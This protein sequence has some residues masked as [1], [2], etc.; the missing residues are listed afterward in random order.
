MLKGISDHVAMPAQTQVA[1]AYATAVAEPVRLRIIAALA[2]APRS[3]AALAAAVRVDEAS[4]F[5]HMRPLELLGLV[6][7]V[8]GAGADRTYMLVREP[9]IDD[10]A[11]ERLPL[12]AR[13]AAAASTVTQFHASAT[14]AVDDGGFDRRDA[15]LTRTRFE[16]DEAGWERA[17]DILARTH[18][19]LADLAARAADAPTLRATATMLLY[20]GHHHAPDTEQAE[21]RAEFS[22]SEGLGRAVELAESL[23][24]ATTRPLTPWAELV[25][26]A[27]ELRVV[28]RACLAEQTRVEP[29]AAIES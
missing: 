24:E 11:Y 14:A 18:R 9:V 3:V 16:F 22:E 27:D 7:A 15:H 26:L 6:E 28:A 29:P 19:E 20:A 4:L 1:A 10:D 13:R 12:P 5:R 8:P 21:P 2:D 25:A 23:Q 17:S